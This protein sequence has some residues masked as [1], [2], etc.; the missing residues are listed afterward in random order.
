MTTHGFM[1]L[2]STSATSE[3]DG[4]SS[5]KQIDLD[6][7][8]RIS[9]DIRRPREDDDMDD[10]ELVAVPPPRSVMASAAE[11]MPP[12]P[13]S[14]SLSLDIT[15]AAAMR[16]SGTYQSLNDAPPTTGVSRVGQ[17]TEVGSGNGGY[18]ELRLDDEEE[19]VNGATLVDTINSF[20][21]TVVPMQSQPEKINGFQRQNDGGPSMPR[22]DSMREG[23]DGEK[24]V[25]F[26]EEDD[27]WGRFR[28]A[29]VG[30][31][32]LNAGNLCGAGNGN[33][34]GCSIQ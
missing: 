31:Q 17:E 10:Q 20:L 7:L 26:N 13:N 30:M 29:V 2:P 25:V 6:D 24:A 1:E 8:G 23:E 18:R 27:S 28:R 3:L 9:L 5:V 33:N 34:G 22:V 11:T 4:L 14:K 16:H 19:V 15:V 12:L 21:S 32:F